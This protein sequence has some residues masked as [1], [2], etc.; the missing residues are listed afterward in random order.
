[1]SLL[2]I[3]FSLLTGGL[4]GVF[5]VGGVLLAPFLFYSFGIDLHLATAV[6]SWSF[7]F[8]G[9]VGSLAYWRMGRISWSAVKWLSVGILPGALLGSWTNAR[10]SSPLLMLILA[11]FILGS[12]LNTIFSRSSANGELDRLKV[13]LLLGLG[14]IT[15]FGSALTGTGGPVIL[16]PALMLLKVQAIAAIAVSQV[17]QIPIAA[18]ASLGHVFFGTIDFGLGTALGITQAVGV[19]IGARIAVNLNPQRHRRLIGITLVGVAAL[20]I[21]RIFFPPI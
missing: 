11:G 1:M 17:A 9:I 16:V 7:L 6:S 18:S 19:V 10:L 4:I 3:A 20:F 12:G 14:F 8:T 2:L 21:L 15:G 5:G 13:S